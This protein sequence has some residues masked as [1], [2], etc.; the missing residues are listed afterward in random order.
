MLTDVM[1]FPWLLQYKSHFSH[2][3]LR[4]DS[5]G[6]L[7]LVVISEWCVTEQSDKENETTEVIS[8]IEWCKE[9]TTR[10]ENLNETKSSV[11]KPL[12]GNMRKEEIHCHDRNGRK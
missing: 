6:I 1:E 9:E 4:A 10:K 2:L 11:S 8:G 12:N 5:S 3:H 7:C